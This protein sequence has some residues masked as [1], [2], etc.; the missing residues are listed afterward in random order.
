MDI[1]PHKPI[2]SSDEEV[3]R[4]KLGAVFEDRDDRDRKVST[5]LAKAVAYL[6]MAMHDGE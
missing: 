1:L 4:R 5:D 6:D 2:T 3:V